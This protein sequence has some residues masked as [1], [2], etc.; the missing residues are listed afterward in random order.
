MVKP[1]DASFTA[2]YTKGLMCPWCGAEIIIAC[3][4]FAIFTSS[5]SSFLL[6][7]LCLLRAHEP[8]GH[9][10]IQ[11]LQT[12]IFGISDGSNFEWLENLSSNVLN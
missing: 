11:Q 1:L 8:H 5:S 7:I 2:R 12:G 4:A 9:I 6:L 3:P 10:Y